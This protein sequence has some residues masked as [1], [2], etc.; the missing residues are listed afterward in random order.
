M[1]GDQT[2]S[3]EQWFSAMLAADENDPEALTEDLVLDVTEQVYRA[4]QDTGLRPSDLAERMK[5]SRSFVSQLLNGRPNMTMRTLVSVACALGLRVRIEFL[6]AVGAN[7]MVPEGSARC[8]HGFAEQLV[9]GPEETT[10]ER[11]RRSAIPLRPQGA[12]S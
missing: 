12:R 9:A 2:L 11:D 1:Q 3:A 4:M 10:E 8:D 5:V 7:P 6:P